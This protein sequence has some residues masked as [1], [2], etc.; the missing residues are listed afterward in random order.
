MR[1][2]LRATCFSNTSPLQFF[3]YNTIWEAMDSYSM[4]IQRWTPLNISTLTSDYLLSVLKNR[5]IQGVLKWGED[6]ITRPL[7]MMFFW[8]SSALIKRPITSAPFRAVTLAYQSLPPSL[9]KQKFKLAS[10]KDLQD[11]ASFM[12]VS[13]IMGFSCKTLHHCACQD[14]K[15]GTAAISLVSI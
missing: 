8:C 12:T 9:H 5:F 6:R 3:F 14:G 4:Q 10:L 2:P 11:H 1:L 7:R 13:A 15:K